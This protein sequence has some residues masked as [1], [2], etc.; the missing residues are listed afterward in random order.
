MIR[1]L[2]VPC[3]LCL[4]LA[5]CGGSSKIKPVE[6]GG[7]PL[8]PVTCFDNDGDGFNGTGDCQNEASVDCDDV[9]PMAYPGA[10]EFCNGKDDSCDG[11]ADEGLAVISYYADGDG[12]GV[13][14]T[15]TGEGCK[16]PPQGSVAQSGDCDDTN[17]K[18][19]PGEAEVCNGVDDD[20]DGTPDNGLPF[21]DFFVD[22]DGDGFGDPMSM[23]VNSCLSSVMGRVPNLGDCDDAN[24]TIKPG[25]TELCNKVDDNCDGQVDNGIAFSS[26]YPDADGDGFGSATAGAESSCAPVPGKVTNNSD[27]NDAS[28]GVKPGAP[29]LC[30]AQDD[31]CDGQVDEGL[32]F[33]TYY[34]DADG[35]GFGNPLSTPQSACTPIAGKVTNDQDCN[36]S[37]PSV[38]PGAPE[39]CNG[40]DDNCNGTIDDGLTF[41]AYYADGD[42]DGFG[43]GAPQSAC[44][45][46]AGRVTNNTDCNDMSP[47]IKPGA[48]ETCNGVDDDCDGQADDGLS[49]SNYYPDADGDGYGQ[50]GAT[51][52]SSC[53]PI[54]G[55]VTNNQDCDDTRSS[56]KPGA[57][58]VCNGL[59]DDCNGAVD[60]GLTFSNWYLDG[61]GDGYGAGAAVSACSQ[62]AG[63]VANATDCNDSAASTHPG[64]PELCNGIDDNCDS[65]VDNGVATQN[66]YPDVDGDG[67]GAAGASPQASCSAVA[68]KVTNNTDCNDSN[69]AIKPGATE[70]CNGVDDNCAGGVDE[71]LTFLN[72]YP[73]V[74][75]DG[76]GAAGSMA[77]SACAPV[78]GKVTN[79]T[80]CNDTNGAIKPGATEVCNGVDDNCAGGIDE[81]LP[82]QS[83]YVD[84]DVDGYGAQGSAAVSSCGPVSGR[85]TNNSDCNDMNPAIKPGAAESCN[86]VDDNCNGQ[87]DEG[88]P[89][90]GAACST[91]QSGVCA[92]GTLTCTSGT[93][94]CVRN[95]AP[96]A[97]RCNALD[98]DCNGQTDE[99]FSGL[100]TS[101]TAGLGVCLATGTIQCNAA[102]TGTQCSATPGSPTA[103]A[104]DGLDNDCDGVVDE[105]VITSTT[106]VTTTAWQDL[107]VAPYYYSSASCAGGVNGA[108][109]DARAGGGLA[110]SVGASGISFQPLTTTG[111]PN[112]G[113][114]TVTSLTYADV[115]LAQAGDGYV[116]AGIWDYNKAEIDIY[117][118]D[119][120]GTPRT[121]R[122]TQFKLPSG[123]SGTGC[124]TLDSLRLVR[125]NGKRV[126]LV[127]REDTVGVR[128]AQVE[129]CNISGTWELRAPGCAS[130]TL[131]PVT[132]VANAAVLPGLGADSTH[133]DWVSSQT[134]PA[135]ATLRTLGVAYRPSATTVSFFQVKEDGTGKSADTPVYSV[136]SPRTLAEPD[137]GYFKDGAGADQFFVA[138]VTK[139]PG[140]PDADLNYWLTNDPTWHYAYLAYATQ[141]GADSIARP[142]VS[143]TASRIW[144]TALRYLTPAEEPSAFKR[145]VMFR[146]TDLSGARVPLGSAVEVSP[147]FGAC[148]DAACRPGDKGGFTANA[149]FGRVYYSG[150]GSSPSGSYASTLTCN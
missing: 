3:T 90:G 144:M 91:G 72:Y 22:A 69:A 33:A 66:Y 67:F 128:L 13:G 29:E 37:S 23:P 21:Q 119:A 133:Q 9:D 143:V 30:N 35:D 95:V 106:D 110:M 134:C 111:A 124:H 56:V 73:D 150:S 127:W 86:N 139:D 65:L 135:A 79:N 94:T 55:R 26:Y 131:T 45:P 54:A 80:D 109:T 114:T 32:T 97:E 116:I 146:M 92:A 16:A 6:D 93:V 62:P 59:D 15:K 27:C 41:T 141:N 31:N 103:A 36:D 68:G 100:G 83:Y 120:M 98:D 60:N 51:A 10:R 85:V 28:P 77:Q 50:A 40:V 149:A 52:Q 5:A 81:G 24:P 74:D 126:T 42:G 11:Q 49:F 4:T 121:Y 107:E 115:D 108:G 20:C 123:C 84:A 76:F 136:S 57:T 17:P 145:Q 129:P 64:A 71:G 137:V 78:A 89:G 19:R 38:K 18:V 53:Q 34:V 102:Q 75:A 87:V 7:P 105:P 99:T 112:G 46:I 1:R 63:R 96:S 113:V 117:Y 8:P 104:C 118:V 125:G 47:A 140:S 43:A 25:V 61:D 88:N 122:Y 2:L 82:T 39:T 130:T 14:S 70:V 44:A 138:Y 147:T 58:E 148:G 132:V 48:P 101:C 142:R 12:D